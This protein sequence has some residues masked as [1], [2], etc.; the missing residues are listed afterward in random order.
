MPLLHLKLPGLPEWKVLFNLRKECG[1]G[2]LFS[3]LLLEINLETFIKF[4]S[5]AD[6]QFPPKFVLF[7]A[8]NR[9]KTKTVHNGSAIVSVPGSKEVYCKHRMKV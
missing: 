7:P 4:N 8:R 1:K 3:D 5:S 6:Q 2:G 9:P